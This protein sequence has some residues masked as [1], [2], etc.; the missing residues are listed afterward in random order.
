VPVAFSDYLE[1]TQGI[2]R[3]VMVGVGD[4]E[5]QL[6]AN[7]RAYLDQFVLR[8]AFLA[9]YPTVQTPTAYVDALNQNAGSPLTAA[10]RADLIA[11]LS[12]GRET[13]AT[14]LRRVAE[15][16]TLR[17]AEFNKAFVLMQYFG[18]LRRNPDDAPDF[19]FDGWR[20]WLDKLEDNGGDFRRAEMVKAFI[21]SI[22][23]R[24]RFGQ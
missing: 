24:Q 9:R 20:F 5:A 17:A 4:W 12:D 15:H 6:E 2:G 8:E 23:Y 13:R 10:E 19:S 16:A 1:D 3:N 14:A 11:R 21:V 22:E 7:K 18:Y